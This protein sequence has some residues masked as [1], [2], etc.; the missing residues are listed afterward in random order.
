MAAML[1]QCLLLGKLADLVVVIPHLFHNCLRFSCQAQ[2]GCITLL[3]SLEMLD[4]GQTVVFVLF[5]NS[6]SLFGFQAVSSVPLPSMWIY[7]LLLAVVSVDAVA[8]VNGQ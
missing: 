4:N 5:Y 6:N 8:P 1:T 3:G 2:I 7:F